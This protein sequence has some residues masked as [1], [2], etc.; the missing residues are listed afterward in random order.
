MAS[1]DG[2]KTD[3]DVDKKPPIEYRAK[4]ST[5]T[6]RPYLGLSLCFHHLILPPLQ[7]RVASNLVRGRPTNQARR[8]A[9]SS[10]CVKMQSA[11]PKTSHCDHGISDP[12][13]PK[14]SSPALGGGSYTLHSTIKWR[15]SLSN[16]LARQDVQGHRVHL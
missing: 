13:S 14:E 11:L 6:S 5:L 2:H 9:S 16:K 3:T 8:Q 12:T 4:E 7:V 10:R 15:C 1:Y